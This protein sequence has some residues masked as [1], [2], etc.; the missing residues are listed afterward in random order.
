MTPVICDLSEAGIVDWET[1]RLRYESY[2]TGLDVDRPILFVTAPT[3]DAPAPDPDDVRP[4]TQDDLDDWVLDPSRVLPR[5]ERLMKRTYYAGDA[6][7]V[8]YPVTPSLAAIQA[9]FMGGD[10]RISIANGSGW[11]DPVI[12]DL[13]TWP[14]SAPIDPGNSWWVKTQTLLKAAAPI[15][16]TGRYV[17]GHPDTQ[18]GGQILDSLRGT[19]RLAMDLIDRPGTVKQAMSRV[20]A[21][22]FEYWTVI[23]AIIGAGQSGHVD[24]LSIYSEEPMVCPECDLSCMISNEMF[25]EFFVPSIRYQCETAGRSIYHLDG[26]GALRHL[27]SLLSLSCLDAIQ[28]VPGAGEKPMVE[29]L[30]L[31]QR[32][33]ASG[34][35]VHIGC[36]AAQALEI[37]SGLDPKSVYIRTSCSTAAEADTLVDQITR[38]FGAEV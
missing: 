15:A 14:K 34:K 29:W 8:M 30:P 26:P 22:W 10:Y 37:A 1:S 21:A 16:A 20:D 28:W 19:E 36:A 4:E 12:D 17:V 32:I 3:P 33:Q 35:G 7:P 6:F 38:Q 5:I 11:C 24:W 31:L 23:N 13:D 18:G 27:D 2:W 25:E 9:A